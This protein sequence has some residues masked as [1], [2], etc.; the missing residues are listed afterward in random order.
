MHTQT[1]AHA[2]RLRA[3]IAIVIMTATGAATAHAQSPYADIHGPGRTHADLDQRAPTVPTTAALDDM[4]ACDAGDMSACYDV[5][6]RFHGGDGVTRDGGNT[7]AHIAQACDGGF[8]RACY[9]LGVRYLLGDTVAHDVTRAVEHVIQA[10]DLQDP[11]ACQFAGMLARDGVGIPRAGNT[12]RG[13]FARACDLGAY[14]ACA[15]LELPDAVPGDEELRVIAESPVEHN[16]LGDTP[17][18][19]TARL[20]DA[21]YMVGCTALAQAYAEGAGVESDIAHAT[22]LRDRACD[23]GELEACSALGR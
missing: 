1:Q 18:R 16:G 5:G 7:I 15:E 10:C 4:D 22:D 11:A 23:W 8:G 14:Q 2:H 17:L 3:F 19:R 6:M 20:C 9:D 21:G 13:F 12:A